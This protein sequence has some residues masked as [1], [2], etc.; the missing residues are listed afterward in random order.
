M[1][2]I[3]WVRV[4]T[5]LAGFMVPIELLQAADPCKDPMTGPE[6]V[7]CSASRAKVENNDLN[8]TYA[9]L[10]SV[11]KKRLDAQSQD[12][13]KSMATA[14]KDWLK[15]RGSHCAVDAT[16][17]GAGGSLVSAKLGE[18]EANETRKRTKYLKTILDYLR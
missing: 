4:A 18:C 12:L 10:R 5:T 15:F 1:R 17:E 14:Q 16:Y 6:S 3:P 13:E 11:L 8:K 9:E 7:A 2:D